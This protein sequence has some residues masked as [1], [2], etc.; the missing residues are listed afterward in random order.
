MEV[1]RGG[2]QKPAKRTD[3]HE[4]PKRRRADDEVDDSAL[5]ARIEVIRKGQIVNIVPS[6]VWRARHFKWNPITFATESER[7]NAK[8]IESPV[9]DKSLATFLEDPS[10]SMIYG[11]S[12]NPDDSKAKYFAAFLVAAHL[13][14]M[15][16]DAN[17][18][19][20]PQYGGFDNPHMSDDRAAPTMLVLTN[21]TPN[22]TPFKLE[23]ARDLLEK[24]SDIPRVVV[25]AGMDP[26]SFL[27]TRL[28]VP[29][30]GIAY[31]SE[32]LVKSQ[33]EVI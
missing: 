33:I 27:T 17:V 12:G 18:I 11:V 2:K 22:S 16:A 24:F 15:G 20:A 23:K 32:A 21:L 26:L 10:T 1:F 14:V 30:H 3:K 6:H 19:W 31:F 29:V 7:L 9:Q 25:I 5:P 4:V 28:H 13:K 8:F